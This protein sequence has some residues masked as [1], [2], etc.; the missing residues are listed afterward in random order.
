MKRGN[1]NN[2][3]RVIKSMVRKMVNANRFLRGGIVVLLF[4]ATACAAWASP[5]DPLQNRPYADLKLLHFGF[6]VGTN[7]QDLEFV[8]NGLPSASGETWGVEVPE[9]SPGISANVMADL[10]LHQYL[11]LRFSPGMYFGSKNVIMLSS[12]G[13]KE[14]QD[15]KS[16]YVALPLDL[17]VSGERYVN[18]RPYVSG[19]L[20]STFDVGKKRSEFLKFN[21]ADL[22]LTLGFGCD[23]YHPF[24]KFI[25]EIKFCFGLT[26][27]LQHDRPDLADN[28]DMLK[29]TQGLKSVR[30]N[31][32]QINFYFE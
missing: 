20:L 30:S 22:Y 8:H 32:V 29:I 26:D 19:G 31:M 24:F 9:F 28:P 5:G 7:I 4:L 6:S 16:A 10:R 12:M 1:N 25:P 23:F 3:Y 14:R 27:I 21:T 2:I 13:V 18:T 15:V 17:K 11:N